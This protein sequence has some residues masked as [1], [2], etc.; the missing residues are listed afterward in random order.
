MNNGALNDS[1]SKWKHEL[2]SSNPVDEE[3]EAPKE[4]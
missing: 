2:R 4:P 3:G 1:L